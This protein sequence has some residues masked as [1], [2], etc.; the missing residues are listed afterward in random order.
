MNDGTLKLTHHQKNVDDILSI[1]D[2]V[3]ASTRQ[4]V[5]IFIFICFY[6][7]LK[8]ELTLVADL[9]PTR[10]PDR[11]HQHLTSLAGL[12]KGGSL[13]H[14]QREA[15][16]DNER[17]DRRTGCFEE[18]IERW[19]GTE[20][21]AYHLPLS[22]R[23]A[24]LTSKPHVLSIFSTSPPQKSTCSFAFFNSE[25]HL[26][27]SANQTRYFLTP[28]STL[29][30]APLAHKKLVTILLCL[31]CVWPRCRHLL[32]S[33]SIAATLLH[34]SR[35]FQVENRR[36]LRCHTGEL[37]AAGVGRYYAW[38]YTGHNKDWLSPHGVYFG[39]YS[40][41]HSGNQCRRRRERGNGKRR[42]GSAESS[43]G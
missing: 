3:H 34:E 16:G 36:V 13:S 8:R 20:A 30:F 43:L 18:S 37:W 1:L 15:H 24:A 5:C 42:P 17:L 28:A 41:N 12:S 26:D 27:S 39:H 9:L 29:P 22:H 23:R 33:I 6:S 10:M 32:P 40:S 2:F 31:Q 7:F 14:K 4:E 19:L 21:R 11:R 35:V 25:S 38:G